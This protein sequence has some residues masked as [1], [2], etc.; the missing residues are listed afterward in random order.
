LKSLER[1]LRGGEQERRTLGDL[2]LEARQLAEAQ[3]QVASSLPQSPGVANAD[4]LR[5][6]A[7]EEE[8]LAERARRLQDGA[9]QSPS[10]GA[11]GALAGRR[12][13]ERMQQSAEALRSAARNEQGLDPKRE[14]GAEEQIA[15][16]LD[17]AADLL[18]AGG[19]AKDRDSAQRSNALARAKE[20]REKLDAITSKLQKPGTSGQR[21]QLRDEAAR[22]LQRATQLLDDLRRQDPSLS[23]G[24]PGFTYEGQGMTFSS[25]GTEGFKQDFA[26]WRQ[27][28]DQ[29]TGALARVEARL[30]KQLQDTQAAERLAAGVD[31]KAPA[32]YRSRV[33][34]YFKAIAAKKT[35]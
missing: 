35:P 9:R 26:R 1:K 6:L 17:N 30:S 13:A 28:R 2:Q 21:N 11:A 20:L 24:G 19:N 15:R 29:A 5:Q 14:A 25:P 31:D 32:A 3:R 27:L 22:E 34:D 18:Q 12:L 8:R 10:T 4:R 33:D 7:G 16:D 23:S